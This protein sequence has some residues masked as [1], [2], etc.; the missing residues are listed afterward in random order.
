MSRLALLA[1]TSLLLCSVAPQRATGAEREEDA[2]TKLRHELAH[3]KRRVIL[4][5]DGCDALYFPTNREVTPAA[6]LEQRTTALAGTHVDTLFYCSIS[7]GFGQFTHHTRVGEV[8]RHDV[9]AALKVDGRTNITSRLIEQGTD[10]LRLVTE[11]CHQNKMECFWSMRMNDTHDAA[12]RPEKPYP[13]FPSLKAQHPE[14]LIGSLTNLPKQGTWSSVD[15]ARPEIRDLAFRYIEEV[16]QRYDIDG[17]ELDFLRHA[18]FFKSVAYGG[19]A[20]DAEREMMTAL[21]RRVRAMADAEGRKRG[22]PIL[23][24]IR[25]PDSVEYS[26]DIGLDLER[27]LAEGLTDLLIATCYSQLNPWEYLVELGHRYGVPVYPG[28]SESRVQGDVPPFKRQA[29]ESY[30]ARALRAWQAGADGIY[31]FNFFNPRAP[32]LKELGDPQLLRTLDRDYYVSVRNGNPDRYLADGKR[33][34]RVPI[35]TPSNVLSVA[36]DQP[37]TVDLYVGEAFAA[38]NAPTVTLHLL[39]LGSANIAVKLNDTPL[40]PGKVDGLWWACPVDPK[41]VRAGRN[42]VEIAA[43][44][45]AATAAQAPEWTAVYTATELPQAPWHGDRPRPH[46]LAEVR[47]GA[48]LLADRG[49]QPGD[50]R[51]YSYPW[52][53][54]PERESVVE[55]RV[56]VLSGWNNIIVA[57][58]VATERVSLYPDRV[59]LYYAKRSHAMNTTDNFHTYRVVV[60]GKDI[61]VFVDGEL[62]LDG[63]GLFTEPA[64]GR[65]DV[66]IGASNSGSLG[67]ALWQSVKLRSS[68]G[69]VSVHDLVM[70]VRPTR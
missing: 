34:Q 22:R 59:A 41:L 16:C 63:V 2:F 14:W 5:N 15:Y 18:S 70:T 52:N 7:S 62:R 31:L 43:L 29:I 19:T 12:H 9:A 57:N 28:L 4:N 53:V 48:L 17:V 39:T 20:S 24:A 36:P 50:Y 25:V 51:Y 68:S 23:I 69:A 26:R 37:Q 56:R 40:G 58:G 10:P 27:W 1:T 35:L 46:T 21:L 47:D 13:L 42:R 45:P 32:M 11:F 61:R 8:L 33:H 67:E 64:A 54:D 49:E 65:N 44:T 38:D 55:A 60:K 66:R 3:R 6:F 30:R